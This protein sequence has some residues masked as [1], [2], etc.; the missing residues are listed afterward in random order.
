M[1]DVKTL[2][3]RVALKYDTYANWTLDTEATQAAKTNANLVLLEGE[4]GICAIESKE[5]GAQTAPTV[6]FKVGNGTTPFKN[7]KWASALAADVYDWAKAANVKLTVTEVEGKASTKAIEF[8][9]GKDAEGKDIIL[10]SLTLDYLTEAEVTAITGAIEQDLA[11]LT[12]RVSTAEGKISGLETAVKT[13]NDTTS[14]IL[15]QAKDYTDE[16]VGEAPEGT[17]KTVWETI[18]AIQKAAYDD[19]AVRQLIND[20]ASDIAENKTAIENEAKARAD[21]IGAASTDDTPATGVYIAIETADKA[22]NDKIGNTDDAAE[23]NTVYG[24]IAKAKADA[25]DDVDT[26]ITALITGEG[27]VAVNTAAIAEHSEA[28]AELS[29]NLDTAVGALEDADDL[30]D[31]RLV[32]VEAFFDGAA[33]DSEGLNDAL[34]KLVDIQTYLNGDGSAAD[35][36]LGQV[37]ANA[38]DIENIYEIVGDE[39][40]LTSQVAEEA[41]KLAGVTTR[42]SNLEEKTA[43]FEGTIKT[44]VDAVSA[45]AEKGVEDAEKA[46]TAAN[47]AQTDATSALN[48][49]GAV[50]NRLNGDDGIDAK[51]A[52]NAQDIAKEIQDRENAILGISNTISDLDTT[53]KAADKTIN[54]RIDTIVSTTIPAAEEAAKVHAEEKVKGLAEGAVADN[55]K[56]IAEIKGDYLKMA[57]LFIIDCGSATEVTHE[58]P[59]TTA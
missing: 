17:T 29:G 47:N 14:G 18:D 24:A 33:K 46:Q 2:Q 58:R 1:A 9:G 53:Y 20:N 43:G 8:V 41:S 44:R 6:L 11:D 40:S 3:T 19:T 57:D 22:I 34:D 25:A 5:Q 4:I 48:R 26:K 38:K 49:V 35:G 37:T 23:A 30:L 39:G 28:I 45:R 52:K 32:K 55:A 12:T 56:D 31:E 50:E 13:I 15:A 54:E 16:L 7:L 21:A 42:V 51:I 36:L 10:K 59:T 27:A